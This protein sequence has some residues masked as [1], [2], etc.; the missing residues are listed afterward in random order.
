MRFPHR[1]GLVGL[2]LFAPDYLPAQQIT[3]PLR[4]NSVR[5]AVIG[6]VGT[7]DK[8]AYDL[9]AMIVK[10]HVKFPFTFAI[11]L[12]DNIYGSERPQDFERK[13][14]T[15]YKT[16]LDGKVEFR[17]ALGNHDD[18]NQ[19]FFK[20]FGMG[21]E[22]YYTFTKG[23]VKFY[24]I[25]S[26]YLDPDQVKW[27]DKELQGKGTTWKIAYF[28]HPLYTTSSRGP[29]VEARKVLEPLFVKYGV[30]VVFNG[31]E[32]MY[33]RIKPQRGIHYFVAGAAAKLNRGDA[34]P[35]GV[36]DKLFDADRSFMLVEVSGDVLYFQTIT[37][38]GTT[39][40]NGTI[41]RGRP[42]ALP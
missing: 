11:L 7:G 32:H 17:A 31:H 8:A 20:P 22:R 30:N 5:F 25:D 34:R 38:T 28:H 29:V 18:P 24:V 13:F 36:N 39:I 37:R 1:A 16:L 41:R 15:P 2:L 27:L 10:S 42:A 9:A 21:G 19:R 6:D 26:N 40:D 14:T 33:E 35:G 23:N 3:L 4:R 12:G